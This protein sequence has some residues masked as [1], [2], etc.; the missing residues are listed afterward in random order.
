MDSTSSKA[1]AQ[2]IIS[3][4]WNA[5]RLAGIEDL[6]APDCVS[7]PSWAE[8]TGGR[9][10]RGA[11]A[12]QKHIL[13]WLAAFPDLVF[14]AEQMTAEDALV[15]TH[16]RIV[17]T[18][19]G[20]WLDLPP[21][22]LSLTIRLVTTQRFAEGK[23]AEEW[24]LVDLLGV[25]QQ[26][27]ILPATEPLLLRGAQLLRQREQ[28]ERQ[29]RMINRRATPADPAALAAVEGCPYY[30]DLIANQSG[31]ELWDCEEPHDDGGCYLWVVTRQLEKI[32][33][34]AYF[35]WLGGRLQRR[36]FDQDDNVY[37]VDV[38]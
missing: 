29:A 10:P 12:Y 34:L 8:R 13:E 24:V 33:V 15:T 2:R 23:L 38:C 37:W 26:L 31:V 16:G 1:L 4:L 18:H 20:H 28:L 30:R 32:Q 3:E 14:Q 5:H 25:L 21:T 6:V 19:S 17:G 22:G 35:R 36:A 7:H 11:V 9:E 27:E